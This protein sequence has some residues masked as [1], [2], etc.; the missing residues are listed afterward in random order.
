MPTLGALV[1]ALCAGQAA[2][3]SEPK[4]SWERQF[5]AD[6]DGRRVLLFGDSAAYGKPAMGALDTSGR[7][8]LLLG[9]LDGTIA[10]FENTGTAANP[11]WTLAEERISATYPTGTRR[12]RRMLDAGSHAAPALADIDGDGDLDLFV[13]AG[14][15]RLLFFRN[16][17]TRQLPLFELVTEHFV[18]PE[19]GTHLVPVFV[20]LNGDRAPDLIVGNG[21][22][23]VYLLVNQGRI[24]EPAFC[25]VLP[26]AEADAEPPCTP[27][28]RL[29]ASIHPEIH[30]APALVDW[31]GDGDYELFVGKSDGTIDYYE[32]RGTRQDPDWRLT[33]PR[34]L[35][36]DE[37]GYAAPAFLDM[38]GDGKPDLIVGNS[39][40]ALVLYTNKDAAGLLDLWK[41]T[42]NL[43]GMEHFARGLE[44][45]VIASG[46]VDGDG[47]LDLIVGDR[48]GGLMWVENTSTTKIPR[49]RVKQE[50]LTAGARRQNSAPLLVDIDGDGDLDLL[51][52]GGEGRIWLLRNTGT[53]KRPQWVLESTAFG[54]IDVGANSIPAMHDIDSN[55]VPDLFV[56]NGRG[57]VIY[58]HNDGTAKAPEFRLVSTRFGEI[59]VGQN[60]A[61]A[62]FDWNE[63][64]QADL[65]IGNREGRLALVA[66]NNPPK[67]TQL[68]A[69][70]TVSTFWEGIQV[71]GYGVPHFADFNGDGKS[72]LMI[73]DGDGNIRLYLNGGSGL[74]QPSP[75]PAGTAV[76]T[77]P[78]APA[79]PGGVAVQ[80]VPSPPRPGV[81]VP[82]PAV[83]PAT[84]LAP[85]PS[86]APE[87]T[88]TRPAPPVGAAAPA[89]QR[90]TAPVAT[91]AQPPGLA[92]R[93]PASGAAGEEGLDLEADSTGAPVSDG[94][95]GPVPPEYKLVSQKL[96][97][98]QVEGKASPAFGDLDGDG[99][100]DLVIGT[101]KGQLLYFRNI[102][103]PKEPKFAPVADF[104]AGLGMFRL[105]VPAIA[106]LDGDGLLD[107]IVGLEDGKIFLLKNIGD[108]TRP[109]FSRLE[110]P[111]SHV[112]VGRGAAP[113]VAA[114]ASKD[115]ADLLIGNFAGNL[116]LYAREGGARSLNFKLVDR[117]F[118][119]LDVGV[120]ST[121]FV[122][123]M[124][125]DGIPD[126]VIGSDGGAITHYVQAGSAKE[127]LAWKKGPDYFKGMRFPPGSTPRL[128]D[129]DG[130]GVQ[131]LIVGTAMGTLF[132]YHN[133]AGREEGAPR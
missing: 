98:I 133:E 28:P 24:T 82:S 63:D 29:I 55:G 116:L 18:A 127:P 130:D 99:A 31:D 80:A 94:K 23:D 96:G 91:P 77:V 88:P 115:A 1:L 124:D 119:G 40:S 61:P 75:A 56:G 108:K 48:N 10:R 68:R 71:H 36:I 57:L 19:L 111:F 67:D 30:A 64:K 50:N 37:G 106:D 107:L 45:A 32:N 101:G 84:A 122:G 52:G 85:A 8:S 54:D 66:N 65:V 6:L 74:P 43:L 38:N 27:A 102:G 60:A 100:L 128:V 78:Q 7:I 117:R 39:A 20:D 95:S 53:A 86:T 22:G 125:A 16:I 44:R 2:A 4:Y 87:P 17:G 26:P 11:V 110:E 25:S 47:D 69:W 70:K 3:Q 131:D 132:L 76:A 34:F 73:G 12:V 49:W 120:S 104:F 118:L 15:G 90:P 126:L 97:N 83:P 121:P 93:P 79:A 103:T 89:P 114:I 59:S 81:A 9:R 14:N 33:Q 35:A 51:V 58:Y 13:G 123:D 109:R 46:D 41:V 72:D 21:A 92:S 112:R 5:Y 42:G 129:L 105:P 113:A 62:F